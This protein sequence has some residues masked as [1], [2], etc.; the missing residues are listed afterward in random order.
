MSC[1][2][3]RC[4]IT[5]I[6]Q[7]SRVKPYQITFSTKDIH[8]DLNQQQ[9]TD[10]RNQIFQLLVQ[11]QILPPRVWWDPKICYHKVDCQIN[12]SYL[13]PYKIFSAFCNHSWE[14]LVQC[15][16][17]EPCRNNR[18]FASFLYCLKS[19]K[20][21]SLILSHPWNGI[22]NCLWIYFSNSKWLMLEGN[23]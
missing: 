1:Y 2:T 12:Y 11:E 6:Q 3:T 20:I 19:T 23:N 14:M 10:K 17:K 16:Y 13:K 5:N 21:T 4:K 8:F 15:I 7:F 22:S 18:Y 9:W